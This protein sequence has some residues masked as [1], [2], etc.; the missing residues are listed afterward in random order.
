M[1]EQI[2]TL[3]HFNSEKMWSLLKYLKMICI[4][5]ETLVYLY[6]L[7]NPYILWSSSGYQKQEYGRVRDKET[8]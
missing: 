5:T 8:V 7:L 4:H 3:P 2:R 6:Y 1:K